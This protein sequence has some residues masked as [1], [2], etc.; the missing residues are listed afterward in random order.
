MVFPMA[1]IQKLHQLPHSPQLK[2]QEAS[3]SSRDLIFKCIH[4]SIG[5]DNQ[6]IKLLVICRSTTPGLG[7]SGS[8]LSPG[9]GGRS[10]SSGFI[11]KACYF[12]RC[13]QIPPPPLLPP[14]RSRKW[15]LLVEPP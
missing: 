9:R 2:L 3:N 10:R 6:N 5:K 13:S 12:L 8:P 4:F 11:L 1:F 14:S 15:S 7:S